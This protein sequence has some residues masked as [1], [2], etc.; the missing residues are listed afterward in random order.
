MTSTSDKTERRAV[1]LLRVSTKEQEDRELS[2]PR[3]RRQIEEAALKEGLV[4]PDD[5]WFEYAES[6][7]L[8]EEKRQGIVA[9]LAYVRERRITC[10]FVV[11]WSRFARNTQVASA[12][13]TKLRKMRCPMRS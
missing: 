9:M 6:G 7:R 1:G 13:R 10:A 5:G 8:P 2:L 4:I 11:D 3:Q 12:V